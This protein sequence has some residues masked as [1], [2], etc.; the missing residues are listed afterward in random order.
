[1]AFIRIIIGRSTGNEPIAKQDHDHASRLGERS[2]EVPVV[3]FC[4]T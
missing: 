3:I 4:V 1:M 2:T